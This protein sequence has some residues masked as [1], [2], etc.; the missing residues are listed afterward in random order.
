MLPLSVV[1]ITKNEENNLGRCLESVI[2]GNPMALNAPKLVDEVLIVDSGSTDQSLAIAK[3]FGAQ[4]LSEPWR[5]FG[6]QKA[7]AAQQAR[8][9]WILSLDA[10]ER[11]TPA[12]VEELKT[13][14]ASLDP[15]TAYA[16]P[17]RSF[18][19]GRWIRFGGW[20]PDRQVRIFHRQ[21]SNWDEAPIH[22]RVQASSYQNFTHPI[23]HF[24]FR[25][26][27]HQI[28]TNNRYSSLLAE[29][30]FRAGKRFSVVKLVFKPYFKFL[31]NYVWKGGFLDGVAGFVIAVNSAHSTLLRWIKIWELE[32]AQKK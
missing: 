19:L 17:R 11:L 16:I 15:K 8:N 25:D 9:D 21:H 1:I 26:V 4:I 32:R 6:A 24:V 14:F 28:E 13:R 5:G 2:G 18:Y 12:F 20:W 29:K 3:K 7:F 27:A 10:D 31:E 23:E 22:E 30:D